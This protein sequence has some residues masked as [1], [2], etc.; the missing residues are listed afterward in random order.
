[1]DGLSSSLSSLGSRGLRG[2]SFLIDG[3]MSPGK[4][5]ARRV[6]IVAQPTRLTT[7]DLQKIGTLLKRWAD[8]P[9]RWWIIVAGLGAV[10]ELLHI[11]WLALRYVLKF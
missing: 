4:K 10:V 6:C 8:S 11:G 1:M 2:V 9:L 7:A 5:A 3:F